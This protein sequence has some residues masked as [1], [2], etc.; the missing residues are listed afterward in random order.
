M[1]TAKKMAKESLL[2]MLGISVGSIVMIL[3][4]AHLAFLHF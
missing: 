1:P 4:S 3:L 2:F